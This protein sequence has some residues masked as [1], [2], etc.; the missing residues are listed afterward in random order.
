MDKPVRLK[1]IAE[2]LGISL[3]TVSR[4]LNDKPGISQ[5]TRELVL[6]ELKQYKDELAPVV[7]TIIPGKGKFIGII[8][9][10]RSGQLDSVYFHHS[11]LAFDE[12]F[13][14]QGYQSLVIP[15]SEGDMEDPSGIP[16]L[17]SDSCEGFI[18][19]GQSLSP[20]F[21]MEIKAL[22]K[23]VVLLENRMYEHHMDC[24]VC[25]D[26]EGARKTTDY[27]IR[28]KHEM[29][30]HVTGPANWYNNRERIA[31]YREAME[32]AG[33]EPVIIHRDDTTIHT[34]GEALEEIRRQLP[35]CTAV[36]AVNDAMAIGLLNRAREE[37]VKVPGELA[38]TGFDDIPWAA[39]TF[40]S[41]TTSR[42]HIE[43]MGELAASRVIQL[44]EDPDTPPV[45]MKMPVD[46][47]IRET[48]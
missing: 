4:V 19:R 33:L 8:G 11:T 23:P 41:L 36:F 38:I 9:R 21:I 37:G 22:G 35:A 18:L 5:E 45:E 2:K 40:P 12:T 44:L 42:I 17:Q 15:V 14:K 27:L 3:S 24:V 39:M 20:R 10:Q 16:A 6:R 29:I 34:G 26:R 13:R 43:K 28:K 1:S 7:R 25:N 31:G 30:V 48:T 32:Q 47:I 46:L